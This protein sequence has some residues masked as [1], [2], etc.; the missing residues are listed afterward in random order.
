VKA[1]SHQATALD[2]ISLLDQLDQITRSAQPGI[3]SN[4]QFADIG[5]DA[6]RRFVRLRLDAWALVVVPIALQGRAC[7]Y[8]RPLDK[9]D[10]WIRLNDIVLEDCFQDIALDGSVASDVPREPI[11]Q[12]TD[13]M[14][15]VKAR[16]GDTGLGTGTASVIAAFPSVELAM[17][18]RYYI[19]C[20]ARELS[21]A[22]TLARLTAD[23]NAVV[24]LAESLSDPGTVYG[25]PPL[26]PLGRMAETLCTATRSNGVRVYI[27]RLERGRPCL[28]RIYRSP[29]RH[30]I[31]TPAELHRPSRRE[32]SSRR[33]LTDW[34]VLHGESLLVPNPVDPS[35]VG[36]VA[37]QAI[38]PSGKH[39]EIVAT[40]SPDDPV[41]D[42]ET[43]MCLAPLMIDD[44]PMGVLLVWRGEGE[45]YRASS[46]LPALNQYAST[47]A[48]GARWRV[49]QDTI[50][51]QSREISTLGNR[52]TS[53]ASLGEVYDAIA[54]GI[55]RLSQAARCLIFLWDTD[56]RAYYCE[57]VWTSEVLTLP[58]DPPLQREMHR[59][60]GAS[61]SAASFLS[62]IKAHSHHLQIGIQ[63]LEARPTLRLAASSS[64]EGLIL[65]L[66]EERSEHEQRLR[67]YD[68][69]LATQA[70]QTYIE[71]ILPLLENHVRSLAQAAIQEFARRIGT[72]PHDPDHVL[73]CAA[74]V[75]RVHLGCD[76]V[77]V[78]GDSVDGLRILA[79]SPAV[80]DLHGFGVAPRSLTAEVVE[81][82][83]P[84]R[85]LDTS[86]S[87]SQ[88]A[89]RLDRAV[90]DRMTAALGWNGVRSWICWPVVSGVRCVG[91]IK[92][93][94][95]GG[96][97]F[98]GQTAMSIVGAVADRAAMHMER[99]TRHRVV[100]S[101]NELTS[102]LA[103]LAGDALAEAMHTGIRDIFNRFLQSGADVLVTA[104]VTSSRP[105][106]FARSPGL[107]DVMVHELQDKAERATTDF[108]GQ[109]ADRHFYAAHIGL[110]GSRSTRGHLFV[111][112]SAPVKG[113]EKYVAH[114]AAR[115]ISILID[116]ERQR[117][118]W[119]RQ[120]GVFRHALVGPVQG[121]LSSA[122]LLHLRAAT[123]GGDPDEMQRLK[124][125]IEAEAQ[126]V[127]S[128]RVNQRLF[129]SDRVEIHP[130]L[131]ALFPFLKHSTE[132]YR[133]MLAARNLTITLEARIPSALQ[134]SYDESLLD[135]AL[136]NLLDNAA[137]YAF[138]NRNITVGAE[139]DAVAVRIW[140]EDEGHG[141][142]SSLSTQIYEAGVRSDRLDPI[143]AIDGIGLGLAMVQR[144][145]Q[146]HDGKLTHTSIALGD[147][148]LDPKHPQA[149]RVRFVLELPRQR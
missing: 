149:H 135:I 108:S 101:I 28:E 68:D 130:A 71:Q 26:D 14:C 12:H 24:T 110:P 56:S 6:L 137:K 4:M 29:R 116:R 17:D 21:M 60:R 79:T 117:H 43:G 72:D 31:V 19:L 78:Y 143:R 82:R 70:A 129:F 35:L 81:T 49:S 46:D 118:D 104:T 83:S 36:L 80:G 140:V 146:A 37:E 106:T 127:R 120:V 10:D 91:L 62:A 88:D 131:R 128:W 100:D 111:V 30:E 141:I 25:A 32:I 103:A 94:T 48:A 119:R 124:A 145:A 109:V 95:S 8:S 114:E 105:R 75:L 76:A 5:A 16:F 40:Q 115:E 125:R 142:P 144:I 86:D 65:I 107:E 134:L 126:A 13:D 69:K 53:G 58:D 96:S 99:I 39:V 90:L 93:L 132:R 64:P 22:A 33:G 7:G 50:R 74:D 9:E 57:G 45:T 98:L 102:T 11:V 113:D 66:D 41:D 15:V 2:P 89:K 34:V 63:A 97:R 44:V 148:R 139:A 27:M 77:L 92:L 73:T 18:G 147:D 1:P 42:K 136:A 67:S 123:L 122:K 3:G 20:C 38:T 54:G 52:I 138:Y 61:Q 51:A 112:T 84:I 55:G 85:I 47:I 23:R 59:P 133:D 121:L 87:D